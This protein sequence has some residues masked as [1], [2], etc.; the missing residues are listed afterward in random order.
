MYVEVNNEQIVLEKAILYIEIVHDL[1]MSKY[2][3][4]FIVPITYTL[5]LAREGTLIVGTS[6]LVGE[7]FAG[8]LVCLFGHIY[9]TLHVRRRVGVGIFKRCQ[10]NIHNIP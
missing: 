8:K 3:G 6:Y 1:L 4:Y 10:H 7:W 9:S 5:G 2:I